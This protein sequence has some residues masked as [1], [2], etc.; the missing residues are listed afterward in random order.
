MFQTLLKNPN[1]DAEYIR[2]WLTEFDKSLSEKFVQTFDKLVRQ[3][4]NDS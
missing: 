3:V 4:K 2:N 1:Y